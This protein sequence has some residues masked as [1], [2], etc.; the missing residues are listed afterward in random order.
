MYILSVKFSDLVMANVY[1]V[2]GN[3]I[4][5]LCE[6]GTGRNNVTCLQDVSINCRLV[7]ILETTNT[8]NTFVL[9]IEG[10]YDD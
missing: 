9:L 10:D 6:S 5:T 8:N 7:N 1:N 3:H 4:H 2:N